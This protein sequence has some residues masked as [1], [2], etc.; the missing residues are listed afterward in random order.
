MEHEVTSKSAIEYRSLSLAA[1]NRERRIDLVHSAEFSNAKVLNVVAWSKAAAVVSHSL[2]ASSS[3]PVQ[4][5]GAPEFAT[6]CTS[7][8]PDPFDAS[9]STFSNLRKLC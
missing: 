4:Y 9:R 6:S 2:D 5:G 1:S 3:P 8:R 7:K